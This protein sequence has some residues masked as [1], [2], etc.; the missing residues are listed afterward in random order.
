[1]A[2]APANTAVSTAN[3]NVDCHDPVDL[4]SIVDSTPDVGVTAVPNVSFLTQVSDIQYEPRVPDGSE[5]LLEMDTQEL[6]AVSVAFRVNTIMD[7]EMPEAET[8]EHHELDEPALLEVEMEVSIDSSH[9]MMM[10]FESDIIPTSGPMSIA[11]PMAVDLDETLPTPMEDV[12]LQ[13]VEEKVPD[14]IMIDIEREISMFLAE[15]NNKL[16]VYSGNDH[17]GPSTEIEMDVAQNDDMDEDELD[18]LV[19]EIEA[20]FLEPEP[21]PEVQQPSTFNTPVFDTL[22]PKMVEIPSIIAPTN[23]VNLT[24]NRLYNRISC[25]THDFKTFAESSDAKINFSTAAITDFNGPVYEDA[26]IEMKE[27]VMPRNDDNVERYIDRPKR[28]PKS[29]RLVAARKMML[30]ENKTATQTQAP[31]MEPQMVV[32]DV[33]VGLQE[34]LVPSTPLL[35]CCP[36]TEDHSPT[37][38]DQKPSTN[39]ICGNIGLEQQKSMPET[40]LEQSAN[41]STST[42]STPDT[43]KIIHHT[44][45]HKLKLIPLSKGKETRNSDILRVL[46]IKSQTSIKPINDVPTIKMGG[47]ILPGGNVMLPGTPITSPVTPSP[48]MT[49]DSEAWKKQ[50]EESLAR[51][52]RS[53]T[54]KKPVRLFHPRKS[55]PAVK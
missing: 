7:I 30:S 19:K 31:A 37:I 11:T 18:E 1:M 36:D 41:G 4:E 39:A 32:S 46:P 49:V 8:T 20:Y 6:E 3:Y 33:L 38:E 55:P 17:D 52:L 12:S 54:R 53:V 16:C 2:P 43:S 24:V 27:A 34:Q 42:P 9:E 44:P 5:E 25:A 14:E 26:S 28:I 22:P 40:D 15:E 10:E 48:K 13:V 21:E 45:T 35:S 23:T 29:R 51:D 47:L 50:K